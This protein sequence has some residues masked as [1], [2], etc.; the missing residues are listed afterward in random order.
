MIRESKSLALFFFC[1]QGPKI[2]LQVLN[3]IIKLLKAQNI[4][5]YKK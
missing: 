5:Q 2:L 3:K 4:Y 1:D